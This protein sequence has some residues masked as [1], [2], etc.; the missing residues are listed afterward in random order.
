LHGNVRK[1]PKLSGT[2]HNVFGIQVGV[3][4]TVAVRCSGEK[5]L[6]YRRVPEFW[7]KEEKLAWLDKRDITWQ[8]LS[9]I[10]GAAWLLPQHAEEFARFDPLT[11][12]FEMHTV[13]VKTNRDDVVYG[14]HRDALA[15]RIEHFIEAYNSEV[16][17][18][19]RS[20]TPANVDDWV[21]YERVKWSETLKLNLQR[22]VYAG[23]DE[24]R[25]R[26]SLYR[27]FCKK[28]L[29]FDPI[30]NERLY[31]NQLVFPSANA[32]NLAVCCTNHSQMPFVVQMSGC[33][34]NE[35]PGGRQ[36]Q[37]FPF[38]TYSPDGSN[39]RENITDAAL[40]NFRLHY[41]N[42]AIA[43]WDIFHYIYAVLHHPAYRE[44]FADNLKRELPRIPFAPDF[45]AF[46]A[47]GREL[48]RLH[49]EYET[50]EPWP[51]EWV[52]NPA[53]PLSYR[54]EDKMRLN[55]DKTALAVNPSL[56]LAGIPPETF[57]YRLGNRSALEWVVDQ[58]RVTE[59]ERSGIKSDPNRED[60][61][62]YIVRLVGQVVRVG[63]ETTRIVRLLPPAFPA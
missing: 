18:Y 6:R 56:T 28:L 24:T 57:E 46:A 61:A 1:N 13:G 3:G 10:A 21:S 7:R 40:E 20:G 16:D 14:F 59:D 4:I 33:L 48:A 23:F 34:P 31:S 54:V 41:R 63:F 11:G 19:K 25:I 50:L 8:D 62:Q 45:A 27:P 42:P 47:A 58:Y 29:Y 9:P 2:K 12:M 38:Y 39:R 43:K 35:A 30:L 26:Q 17:R 22:G 55:K 60:D 49:V 52:E 51:L 32:S 53:C 15:D 37:T 44:K 36:G 5:R